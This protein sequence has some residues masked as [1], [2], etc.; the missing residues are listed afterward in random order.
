MSFAQTNYIDMVNTLKA[1]TV[2]TP[3]SATHTIA[4]AAMNT[5]LEAWWMRAADPGVGLNQFSTEKMTAFM[6]IF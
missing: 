2:P 3:P 5:L 6:S 1:M 4:Q